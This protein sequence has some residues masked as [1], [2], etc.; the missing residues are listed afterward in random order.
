MALGILD[1]QT[2]E[3]QFFHLD[4]GIIFLER[5]SSLR[6]TCNSSKLYRIEASILM[7][8]YR[9][10]ELTQSKYKLLTSFLLEKQ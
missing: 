9:E 5:F 7:S 10:N 4:D 1:L 3:G 6:F 8:S 2:S